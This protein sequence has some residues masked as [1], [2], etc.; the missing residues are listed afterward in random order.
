V[1]G[2]AVGAQRVSAVSRKKRHIDG[3]LTGARL[4]PRHPSSSFA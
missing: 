4:S 2:R 1:R 3:A